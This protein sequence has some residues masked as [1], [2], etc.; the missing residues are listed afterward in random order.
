MFSGHWKSLP[1]KSQNFSIWTW[2]FNINIAFEFE[3]I[4]FILD[5]QFV[6]TNTKDIIIKIN[7]LMLTFGVIFIVSFFI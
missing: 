2:I 4:L 3:C 5:K 6:I 7:D 1:K